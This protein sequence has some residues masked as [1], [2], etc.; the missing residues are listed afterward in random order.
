MNKNEISFVTVAATGEKPAAE[1]HAAAFDD[2]GTGVN[3]T[4]QIRGVGGVVMQILANTVGNYLNTCKEEA[5]PLGANAFA[6]IVCGKIRDVLGDEG[7]AALVRATA[8]SA[9]ADG[10]DDDAEV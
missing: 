4:C 6:M 2:G 3:V 10:G 1:I 5:G 9:P 7:Y 8:G